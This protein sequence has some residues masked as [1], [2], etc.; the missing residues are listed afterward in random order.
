M[1]IV[2]RNHQGENHT[3]DALLLSEKQCSALRAAIVNFADEDLDLDI[4]ACLTSLLPRLAPSGGLPI[5]LVIDDHE[6]WSLR[7][8]PVAGEDF[9]LL[10][11]M[12]QRLAEV[13][14]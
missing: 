2:T 5:E 1:D 13:L 10:K 4:A 11:P 7:A 14:V 3:V 8:L 6:A 9:A 12:R